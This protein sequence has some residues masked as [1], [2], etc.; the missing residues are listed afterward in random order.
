MAKLKICQSFLIFHS[1]WL[2]YSVKNLN[3][4]HLKPLWGQLFM[5][6]SQSCFQFYLYIC[7]CAASQHRC[8]SDTR[9]GFTQPTLKM[10][11]K[12]VANKTLN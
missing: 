3:Q 4:P 7:Q 10:N 8:V 9:S 1:L 6:A 5:A 12:S 11:R 2:F